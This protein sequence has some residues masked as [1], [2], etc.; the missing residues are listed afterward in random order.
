MAQQLGIVDSGNGTARRRHDDGTCDN[1]TRERAPSDFIHTRNEAS[2]RPAQVAFD[3]APALSPAGPARG[4]CATGLLRG[5]AAGGGFVLANARG[6]AGEMTEVVQL[7]ATNA[8]ATHD[9]NV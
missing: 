5:G 6:L 4:H 7:G 3:I 2:S 1:G 9:L 8:A